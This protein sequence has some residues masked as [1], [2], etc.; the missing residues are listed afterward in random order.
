[1]IER[2]SVLNT[3]CGDFLQGLAFVSVRS[4]YN[5]S[6]PPKT[7]AKEYLA[8]DAASYNWGYQ[9]YQ[10]LQVGVQNNGPSFY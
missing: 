5:P 10:A 9:T 4:K 6:V 3:L 7:Y 2:H 8:C 1:M